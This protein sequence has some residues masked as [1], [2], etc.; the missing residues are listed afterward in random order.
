MRKYAIYGWAPAKGKAVNDFIKHLDLGTE[1]GFVKSL[2][3]VTMDTSKTKEA[4]LPK[5]QDVLKKAFEIKMGWK[6]VMVGEIKGAG[7]ET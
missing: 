6:E 3:Y 4:D 7:G 5:I 1:G 2:E